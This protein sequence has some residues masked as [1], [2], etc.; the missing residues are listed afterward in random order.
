MSNTLPKLVHFYW[1][2]D[3]LPWLRYLT[4]YSFRKFNPD[5]TILLYRRL[6]KFKTKWSTVEQVDHTYTTG[7]DYS[8][9]LDRIG[10]ETHWLGKGTRKKLGVLA[11]VSDVHASDLLG[12]WCLVKDGGL[13][14]DLDYLFLRP[15]ANLWDERNA[16]EVDV[17]LTRFQ[18]FNYQEP[19]HG[20]LPVSVM[21]GSPDNALFRDCYT[22][23]RQNYDATIY[24]SCGAPLLQAKVPTWHA[25]QKAYPNYN[26]RR[27]E[28]T[29]FFPLSCSHRGLDEALKDLW[30]GQADEWISPDT[31]G[32]HWYGNSPYTKEWISKVQPG[33]VGDFAPGSA[34]CRLILKVLNA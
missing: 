14:A 31:I 30:G 26:F 5:W 28:D 23:A 27:L 20:Y 7:P 11:G 2:S 12:W 16:A 9:E 3:A 34:M 25:L 13:V 6:S 22:E 24:E 8:S 19:R 1:G 18:T 32:L 10:V 17:G 29:L 21:I 33:T 4:L 15:I